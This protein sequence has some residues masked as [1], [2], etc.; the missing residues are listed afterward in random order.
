MASPKT[1]LR[2]AFPKLGPTD[3]KITSEEDEQYN[4]VAH[5]AD[6]SGRF[7]DPMMPP[8]YYWPPGVARE[9]TLSSFVAAYA[10]KGYEPTDSFDAEKGYEK[11]AIFV[12]DQGV[13]KHAAKQLP[14][15]RWTSKL[16]EEW[17]IEHRTLAGLSGKIYG[18]PKQALRRRKS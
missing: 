13:P 17:D 16:G 5:A 15:G 11:V 14:N 7:W 8:P 1:Q 2:N 12:D 4:C 10:T 18:N 9:V 3:F 6:E